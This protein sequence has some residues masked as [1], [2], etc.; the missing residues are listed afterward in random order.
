M[1]R[2]CF[3][4]LEAMILSAWGRSRAATIRLA[5][6]LLTKSALHERPRLLWTWSLTDFILIYSLDTQTTPSA[7][8]R[9]P[10]CQPQ[11][12]RHRAV[13]TFLRIARHSRRT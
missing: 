12:S 3:S 10:I 5:L 8:L 11:S 4:V 9:C 6:N 1:N 2:Y 7:K 13:G